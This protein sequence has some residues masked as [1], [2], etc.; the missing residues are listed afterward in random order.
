MEVLRVIPPTSRRLLPFLTHLLLALPC[1]AGEVDPDTN[2][3]G[4]MSNAKVC[5]ILETSAEQFDSSVPGAK[6]SFQFVASSAQPRPGD[7]WRFTGR[8]NASVDGDQAACV[9]SGLPGVPTRIYLGNAFFIL[10]DQSHAWLVAN[11]YEWRLLCEGDTD[12]FTFPARG[13]LK[14]HPKDP[15]VQL[16]PKEI[17]ERFLQSVECDFS[18]NE[19][20]RTWSASDAEQSALFVSFRSARDAKRYGVPWS[21]IHGVLPQGGLKTVSCPTTTVDAP[22]QVLSYDVPEISS[23]LGARPILDG[24]INLPTEMGGLDD[25]SSDV[26]TRM[27]DVLFRNGDQKI[28]GERQNPRVALALQS[29]RK[30]EDTEQHNIGDNGLLAILAAETLLSAVDQ[31]VPR[32]ESP[33]APYYPDDPYMR[34]LRFETAVGPANAF[35]AYERLSRVLRARKLT[36]MP[37]TMLVE[38]LGALGAPATDNQASYLEAALKSDFERAVLRSRL[39]FACS[40]KLV[41]ACIDVVNGEKV[42]NDSRMIAAQS[43]AILDETR[44]IPEE[45]VATWLTKRISQADPLRRRRNLVEISR[46][47]SGCQLLKARVADD[48]FSPEVAQMVEQILAE[49]TEWMGSPD[50]VSL[51]ESEAVRE[52]E[53]TRK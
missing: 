16:R 27:W 41:D 14:S 1:D 30:F 11:D 43:L 34:W 47:K 52:L 8:V 13:R 37:R 12:R 40:P 26:A 28:G 25:P 15:S 31:P 9:I 5:E 46:S 20:T 45:V 29:I 39:G 17:F 32:L 42:D 21:A 24:N 6:F 18:W 22:G 19:L 36:R 44:E 10:N 7:E 2:A 49:R 33:I 4:D 51:N 3:S 38:A 53:A 50:S 23:A 48:S 35:G